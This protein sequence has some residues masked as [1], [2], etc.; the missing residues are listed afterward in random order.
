MRNYGTKPTNFVLQD[1]WDAVDTLINWDASLDDRDDEGK[2][3]LILAACY[4]HVN[5][6]QLLISRG[7]LMDWPVGVVLKDV[8][9][10]AG[11]L[12]ACPV[13]VKSD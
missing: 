5:M 1:Q 10:S 7:W 8:S 3:S 2:S 12:G 11:G 6:I 13:P 9:V 4:G